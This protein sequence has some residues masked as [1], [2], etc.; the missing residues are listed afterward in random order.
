MNGKQPKYEGTEKTSATLQKALSQTDRAGDNVAV[1]F[2]RDGKGYKATMVRMAVERVQSIRD[3]MEVQ[4][5]NAS[6]AR[7]KFDEV[8]KRYS[9]DMLDGL[10]QILM[11]QQNFE[12]TMFSRIAEVRM[13]RRHTFSLCILVSD[14][15]CL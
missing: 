13:N 1:K 8:A 9:S 7:S 15:T 6:H 3:W 12:N 2:V 11:E 10:I 14:K 4:S 5:Q